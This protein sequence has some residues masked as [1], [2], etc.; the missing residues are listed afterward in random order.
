MVMSTHRRTTTRWLAL[1]ASIAGGIAMLAMSLSAAS[2]TVIPS[3]FFVVDDQQG[4]NDVPGQ[5]DLTRMGRD[6]SD[7]NSYKIFMSWDSTDSWTGTGQTGDACALF[8]KNGNGGIDFVVCGQ[9]NNPGADPTKVA[10]TANSPFAFSCND[11]KVDRCGTPSPVAY[12][13]G[14]QIISGPL[15]AVSAP[16]RLANLITDTDPFAAGA[17]HPNDSTLEIDML[18]NGSGGVLPAGANL[19]NVCSYPSAGNGGNNNPFDCITT[20]GSGF[21]KIVKNV[22]GGTTQ[23]FDFTVAPAPPSP[24]ASTYTLSPT[25]A[26]SGTD[27]TG[28]F[29]ALLTSSE[30]VTE[31]I[32]TGWSLSSAS[33]A[34]E[35]VAGTSGSANLTTGAI[36]G[37]TIA[38][39]KVTTCTFNDAPI[40]PKLTVTKTVVNNSGGTLHATDFSF[41][42]DGGT[43]VAFTQDG[44]DVLK[45]KNVLTTLGAGAHQLAEPA[46]SGYAASSWGGD[47]AAD[48][49]ITL[50][51]GDDKTCTITNDD[52]QGSLQIVKRVVNDNGGT[53]TISNFSLSSTAGTLV[54]GSG[55]A[56]G[57]NTLKYTAGALNVN[58][59]SYSLVE[60]DVAGYSEGTW[61]CT[62][63]TASPA[64]FNAGSVTVANGATVVCTITNDDQ[65]GSLQIVKRVVNDNGGT[66]GVSS[67]GLATNA[68]SLSFDAGV[69]DGAN[70]K[71]YTATAI[72]VSAGDYSLT[73]A[74][75]A[76]Y[77][78]GTWGCTGGTASPTTFNAGSVHVDN[79]AT[80]VCT[81][82]NN[83]QQASPSGSTAQNYILFDSLTMSGLRTG[84]PTPG[85]LSFSLW[86]TKTGTVCSDIVGSP[87]SVSNITANTTYSMATG[88]A[89]TNAGTYYWTVSYSGDEFNAPFTTACGSEST[90]ISKIQ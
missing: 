20:P 57:A 74:D 76:G 36:T 37:I 65:Q 68:G 67:F 25:A 48:G 69:A 39:G 30:S 85:T 15:G 50:A 79:G 60:T 78:E 62:G 13:W 54:F 3:G 34:I 7:P 21:L 71:T 55:V 77:S 18:K 90:T 70:T 8:D 17:N 59:G 41:S 9:I 6:D 5:V 86:S 22:A 82:T 24:E 72:S 45:G 40:Q 4:A 64:T 14:T 75:T 16:N 29:A 19:V 42:V 84:A 52:Q 83:D 66:L 58:A 89:V 80:V 44:S 61:S 51:F 38:S 47:C 56:D 26:K 49:S 2:A 10:Q 46:V 28:S 43:A 1:G 81:I 73:E 32:P 27:D 11:K 35:G 53:K 87:V 63:G 23:S 31:S 33:C 88:I 12:T